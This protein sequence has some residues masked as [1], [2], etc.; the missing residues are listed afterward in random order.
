MHIQTERS[1]AHSPSRPLFSVRPRCPACGETAVAA[2]ASEFIDTGEIR[3]L[4][5]CDDCAQAFVTTVT[6]D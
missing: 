2:R 5:V 3:H 6:R 1:T 4:W